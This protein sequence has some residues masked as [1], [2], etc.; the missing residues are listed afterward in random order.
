MVWRGALCRLPFDDAEIAACSLGA[1]SSANVRARSTAGCGGGKYGAWL[2]P[3]SATP[4][5]TGAA[6]ASL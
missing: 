4:R 6:T 3:R 5:K 1:T 2:P